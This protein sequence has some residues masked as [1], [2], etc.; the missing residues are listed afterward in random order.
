[1]FDDDFVASLPRDGLL[2]AAAICAAFIERHNSWQSDSQRAKNFGEYVEALALADAFVESHD[3]EMEVPRMEYNEGASERNVNIIAS[4]F[5]DWNGRV[6]QEL[7][8]KSTLAE[9]EEAKNRY[10]SRFGR[11]TV[12]EFA[13][14]DFERVQ[15]LINELR[16]VLARSEDF[17]EDHKRR[18]LKKLERLQGELHK[19]MSDLDRF[20]GFFVDAGIA[21]GKFWKEAEPFAEGVKEIL[22][23]VCRTQ[24][25]AENVEKSLPLRLLTG[26]KDGKGKEET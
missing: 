22:Q 24:A 7:R 16:E 15:Q 12:Y 2:G 17:E 23:I 19:K 5:R 9:F 10:A 18:L 25:R 1:M 20:W 13:D 3:I 4:F 14:D 6:K 26:E 21:L 8:R 11:G